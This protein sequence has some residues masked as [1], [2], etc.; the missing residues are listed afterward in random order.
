MAFH[1]TR[2]LALAAVLVGI[3]AIGPSTHLHAQQTLDEL[4]IDELRALAE[5]GDAEARHRLGVMYFAGLGVPQD[6]VEAVQWLRLA[7]DQGFRAGAAVPRCDVL[8][9]PRRP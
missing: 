6:D 4:P 5:Q 7:A 2:V 9:G 3:S 8:G 1:H